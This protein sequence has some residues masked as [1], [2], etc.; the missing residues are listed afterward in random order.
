MKVK[1]HFDGYDGGG[2]RLTTRDEALQPTMMKFP[3]AKPTS[4]C[5]SSS[6]PSSTTPGMMAPIGTYLL[7]DYDSCLETGKSRSI[8]KAKPKCQ[9]QVASRVSSASPAPQTGFSPVPSQA[10]N[11]AGILNCVSSVAQP[12]ARYQP[13]GPP[14]PSAAM[15]YPALIIHPAKTPGFRSSVPG[16]PTRVNS[17]ADDVP[18]PMVKEP[19]YSADRPGHSLDLKF[20]HLKE[21]EREQDIQEV[22]GE[23]SFPENTEACNHGI[24][25]SQSTGTESQSTQGQG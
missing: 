4:T 20:E 21:M 13:S 23:N 2:S 14:T 1:A 11:Q 24:L 3:S 10:W 5:I 9:V 22:N 15:G 7:Q 25:H 8:L 19:D 12:S 18:V 16:I 17:C 6:Q